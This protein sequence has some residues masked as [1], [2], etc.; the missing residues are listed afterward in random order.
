[1]TPA[2]RARDR[3]AAY[4][5]GYVAPANRSVTSRREPTAGSSLC[6]HL[7]LRWRCGLRFGR[8]R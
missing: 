7:K 1:M 4:T 2:L 5:Y 3:G 8:G 6:M